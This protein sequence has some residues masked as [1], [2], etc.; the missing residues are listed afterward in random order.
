MNLTQLIR[1][2]IRELT[3]Y[4]SAREEFSGK[5][6]VFL[7]ANEN[8]LGSVTSE[9]YNRYPDPMQVA[10][11]AKLSALK[12]VSPEQ[13]F[14]GNGSDEAIDL[15]YRAFCEPKKDHVITL[16]PTYGMYRV[17]AD[18]NQIKVVPVPLKDNFQIDLPQVMVAIKPGSKMIFICSPNNPSGN[19]VEKDAI[20]AI[21]KRAPGLVIVDEAYIDFAPDQSV[22]PLLEEYPNLVVLQTFSKAWGL[23]N[24]RL[25]MAFA[26]PT[27]IH[28]LNKIKPPYNVNGL[29]QEK[30][31]EALSNPERKEEM[32][33]QLIAERT[34][35]QESLSQIAIVEQVYPSDANFLLVKVDNPNQRYEQMLDKGTI[36]RNR[37]RLTLCEG[38]LRITVGSKEENDLL[39]T[40]LTELAEAGE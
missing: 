16:P 5:A 22:I 29:T 38:C 24:L 30:A 26:H 20:E 8:A 11:K 4:S 27:I 14:L 40:Q 19:L 34:R 36:L 23:A 21:L 9:I 15:L 3:P 35:L 32:V 1:P 2:H 7:D 17:S 6:D 37:S 12:G 13:I 25:G 10:V 18:L 33:I 31:L 28:T 39:L